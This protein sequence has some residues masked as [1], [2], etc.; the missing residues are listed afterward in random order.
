MCGLTTYLIF[1]A[2]VT[3]SS[4]RGGFVSITGHAARRCLLRVLSGCGEGVSL[5]PRPGVQK[6]GRFPVMKMEMGGLRAAPAIFCSVCSAGHAGVSV[7]PVHRYFNSGAQ[8]C[9][10]SLSRGGACPWSWARG[11]GAVTPTP[12]G[13]C[14]APALWNRCQMRTRR[15]RPLQIRWPTSPWHGPLHG[16]PTAALSISRATGRRDTVCS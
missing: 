12:P 13:P 7:L 14:K 10:R 9:S 16:P 5:G 11:A 4:E 1:A 6:G 2:P 15:V 3:L 8:R